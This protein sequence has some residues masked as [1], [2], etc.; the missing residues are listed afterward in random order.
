MRFHGKEQ[1]VKGLLKFAIRR[2]AK[3]GHNLILVHPN[4]YAMV[5]RFINWVDNGASVKPEPY[6]Q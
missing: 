2:P 4:L 5:I 6:K 1:A 3:N